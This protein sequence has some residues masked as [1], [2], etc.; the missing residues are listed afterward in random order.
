MGKNLYKEYLK[1]QKLKEDKK[2]SNTEIAKIIEERTK[3]FDCE[4]KVSAS[5]M[6]MGALAGS[7]I[8]F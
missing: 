4:L 2:H 7:G 1:K 8:P 3:D 5:N 6:D